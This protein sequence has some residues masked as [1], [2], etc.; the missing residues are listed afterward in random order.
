MLIDLTTCDVRQKII[1][2]VTTSLI[3]SGVVHVTFTVSAPETR[4]FKSFIGYIDASDIIVSTDDYAKLVAAERS[5]GWCEDAHKIIKMIFLNNI[6]PTAFADEMVSVVTTA[7]PVMPSTE[8]ETVL[9]MRSI[10]YHATQ[11]NRPIEVVLVDNNEGIACIS[12][13]L[14]M[15]KQGHITAQP[16]TA[17]GWME[18]ERNEAFSTF[19]AADTLADRMFNITTIG[20]RLFYDFAKLLSDGIYSLRLLSKDDGSK[21]Q[22]EQLTSHWLE[23]SRCGLSDLPNIVI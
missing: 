7:F 12:V 10:V 21:S 2:S 4:E 17:L 16:S 14:D 20:D 3:N 13:L 6:D 22:R 1:S 9:Y 23:L 8:E 15:R 5:G 19:K 18:V 11:E